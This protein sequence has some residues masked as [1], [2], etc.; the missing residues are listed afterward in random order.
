MFRNTFPLGEANETPKQE[1]IHFQLLK[2][3]K[4]DTTFDIFQSEIL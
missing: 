1:C 4:I 2:Y 3:T